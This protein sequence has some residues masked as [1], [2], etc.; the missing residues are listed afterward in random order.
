MKRL[1]KD[2]CGYQG[3]EC[4][5]PK[6]RWFSSLEKSQ[7]QQSL[8]IDSKIQLSS[9]SHNLN[10]L[11]FT[12]DGAA[13]QSGLTIGNLSKYA[14]Q[15]PQEYI[16]NFYNIPFLF[17]GIIAGTEFIPFFL[18]SK[19]DTSDSSIACSQVG[20]EFTQLANKTLYKEVVRPNQK[21]LETWYQG[22]QDLLEDVIKLNQYGQGVLQQPGILLP[23]AKMTPFNNIAAVAIPTSALATSFRSTPSRPTYRDVQS[24]CTKGFIIT[25]SPQDSLFHIMVSSGSVATEVAVQTD[26][27]QGGIVKTIDVNSL[28]RSD[29]QVMS[30]YK[31][32]MTWYFEDAVPINQ[33]SQQ[34]QPSK[35][36]RIYI[37]IYVIAVYDPTANDQ[38]WKARIVVFPSVKSTVTGQPSAISTLQ[39]QIQ[40]ITNVKYAQ[41]GTII[42]SQRPDPY[43]NNGDTVYRTYDVIQTQ[44][45][46]VDLRDWVSQTP[47]PESSEGQQTGTA[48]YVFTMRPNSNIKEW[49]PIKDC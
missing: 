8:Y 17:E 24:G 48:R 18:P 33:E 29:S 6:L 43:S 41:I 21:Y 28:Q 40:K 16:D 46:P 11:H 4:K 49:L 3:F 39:K 5:K 20:L 22:A 45:S 9:Y 47:I 42:Y 27:D 38:K 30:E 44:C 1:S 2:I 36:K 13:V 32:T 34:E 19:Q 31:N 26:S 37:E 35:Q 25:I 15:R 12:A 7:T 14:V 10:Q 23:A